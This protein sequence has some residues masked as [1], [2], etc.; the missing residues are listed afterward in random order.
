M[1]SYICSLNFRPTLVP[2][3]QFHAQILKK[4]DCSKT[5]GHNQ[6]VSTRETRFLGNDFKFS[7]TQL[8]EAYTTTLLVEYII[9]LDSFYFSSL[10]TEKL[11]T[12][13]SFI[14]ILYF[15]LLLLVSPFTGAQLHIPKH[16][17][18]S[19]YWR[20]YLHNSTNS[21]QLQVYVMT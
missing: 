17:G 15:S 14:H 3:M 12:N 5:C 21:K 13:N 16:N 10:F 8:T 7:Q 6:A 1:L 2:C 19:R 18:C 4:T 11:N 20:K 9:L